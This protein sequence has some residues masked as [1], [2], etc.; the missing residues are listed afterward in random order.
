M[1]R[2]WTENLRDA[3]LPFLSICVFD[4]YL[5]FQS[6]EKDEEFSEVHEAINNESLYASLDI[7]F[8]ACCI[9]DRRSRE[10]SLILCLF[11]RVRWDSAAA[12]RS[13]GLQVTMI[14]HVMPSPTF[15]LECR[16]SIYSMLQYLNHS[17]GSAEIANG[18][19]DQCA[20]FYRTIKRRN[21]LCE[22]CLSFILAVLYNSVRIVC[23]ICRFWLNH[24][25]DNGWMR[26]EKEMR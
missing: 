23:L 18:L 13:M 24:G 22:S 11:T 16:R 7:E 8:T 15:L 5:F 20:L 14:P 3:V 21:L 17:V 25:H 12:E 1:R 26:G 4:K 19:V 10:S 2:E 9:Y 6:S